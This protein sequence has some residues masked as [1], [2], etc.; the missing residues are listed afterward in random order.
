MSFVFYDCETTGTEPAFYQI[1][2]F[3]AIR[4][5]A[6][7]NEVDRFEVRS[8]L[9]PRVVPSPG[10]MAITG[11]SIEDITNPTHP[12]HY[13]MVRAIH[14]K[15]SAW[16]PATFLG[17]NSIKFD[18]DLLRQALYQRSTRPILQIPEVIAAAM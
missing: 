7:F 1:L 3:A 12:S 13:Q 5:D 16:S 10:A 18:E 15:L 6:D 4:T 2:Q 14:A 11:M 17:Y 9:L 8:R